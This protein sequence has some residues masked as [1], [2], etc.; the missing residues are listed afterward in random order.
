MREETS[1]EFWPWYRAYMRQADT[2]PTA[3]TAY[4]AGFDAGARWALKTSG[5]LS[6]HIARF[7]ELMVHL[8]WL[9]PQD[10]VCR[11]CEYPRNEHPRVPYP[12]A[13]AHEFE[14]SPPDEY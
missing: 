5:E 12:G 7:I 4:S 9:E 13:G 3:R 6:P 8:G 14:P 1:A 2:E 11:R 10:E